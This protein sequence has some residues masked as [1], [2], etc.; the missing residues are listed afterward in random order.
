MGLVLRL[1]PLLMM[2][3]FFGIPLYLFWRYLRIKERGI[4]AR[5]DDLRLTAL[6]KENIEL[7]HRLQ[8]IES[9]VED[10]DFELN[11]KLAAL[12]EAPPEPDDAAFARAVQV[13]ETEGAERAAFRSEDAPATPRDTAEDS[14][15]DK[16]SA[17]PSR[18]KH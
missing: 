3:G 18:P 10:T 15:H 8:L 17:R 2:L 11:R 9:I 5:E 7:K 16:P 4:V 14:G 6:E 12:P 13:A 1:F